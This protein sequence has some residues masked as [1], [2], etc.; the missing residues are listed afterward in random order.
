MSRLAFRSAVIAEAGDC[1][2][3]STSLPISALVAMSPAMYWLW[4]LRPLSLKAPASS[5]IHS[6]AWV[7][8]LVGYATLNTAWFPPPEAAGEAAGLALAAP[9][10]AGLA[11]AAAE[12]AGLALAAVEPAGLALAGAELGAAA[13]G[14]AG[15]DVGAAL[16]AA[17]PPQAAS[18]APQATPSDARRRKPRRECAA[19]SGD[20]FIWTSSAGYRQHR[21]E[22]RRC[23]IVRLRRGLGGGRRL[24]RC[25]GC[26]AGRGR[27]A[28]LGQREAQQ[29]VRPHA[30]NHV[31]GLIQDGVVVVAARGRADVGDELDGRA[32]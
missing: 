27:A 25:A 12:P 19:A 3:T 9:L 7:P 32:A 26:A 1:R 5:A 10:A 15:D 22:S 17:A 14:E 29:S 20:I 24:G 8:P 30:V 11:L 21:R 31:A 28:R 4:T 2:T 13:L 18:T 16:G 23:A 6:G